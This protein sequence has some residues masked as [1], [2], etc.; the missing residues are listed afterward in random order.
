M[1]E[2][3]APAPSRQAP[4]PRRR[5]SAWGLGALVGLVAGVLVYLSTSPA[6]DIGQVTLRGPRH[7]TASAQSHAP[8]G[9][10]VLWARVGDM[11]AGIRSDPRVAEVEAHRH[12]PNG[13]DVRLRPRVP[14]A[15]FRLDGGQ[16][17]VV[18]R[19]GVLFG[20]CAEPPDL[21]LLAGVT[22]V[23][24]GRGWRIGPREIGAARE[25]IE[26][27]RALGLP[28]LRKIDFL[29]DGRVNAALPE[30]MLIKLGWPV[31]IERKLAVARAAMDTADASQIDY[32]DVELPEAGVMARRGARAGQSANSANP[33]ASSLPYAV[34]SRVGPGSVERAPTPR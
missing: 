28:S 21:V 22:P 4:R 20:R 18:D 29:P 16:Y 10:N 30:G 17:G 11:I 13:L 1:R 34:A 8:V 32:V 31:R 15:C 14:F 19:D 26:R 24:A 5:R 6:F 27:A 9:Q 3:G 2:R 25:I 23:A 33:N 7:L 12:L